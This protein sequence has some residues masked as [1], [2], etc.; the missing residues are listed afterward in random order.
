VLRF[1]KRARQESYAL[2]GEAE[3]F[4]KVHPTPTTARKITINGKTTF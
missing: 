4:F 1:K 2:F 3:A